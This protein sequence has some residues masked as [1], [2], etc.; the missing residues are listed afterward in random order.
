MNKIFGSVTELIESRGY[1]LDFQKKA[2]LEDLEFVGL[3]DEQME[4]M[5]DQVFYKLFGKGWND[6][7]PL[8]QLDIKFAWEGK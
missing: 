8:E 4:R 2:L 5:I 1:L 3:N 6:L 7:T